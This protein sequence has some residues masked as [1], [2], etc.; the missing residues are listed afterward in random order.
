MLQVRSTSSN[1]S[2]CVQVEA[3]LEEQKRKNQLLVEDLERTE[4]QLDEIKDRAKKYESN[5][6]DTER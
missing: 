6:E 2:L 4:D 5:L 1:C 3:E